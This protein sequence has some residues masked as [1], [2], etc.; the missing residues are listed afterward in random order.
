MA[1]FATPGIDGVGFFFTSCFVVV[2]AGGFFA[3]VEEEEEEEEVGADDLDLG[4]VAL[5][6]II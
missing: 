4:I 6:C 5:R 2:A 3:L 1:P